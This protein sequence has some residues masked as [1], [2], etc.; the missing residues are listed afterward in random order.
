[1]KGDYS[2][3]DCWLQI[4]EITK[5]VDTFYIYSTVY[6]DSSFEDG[7]SD[8]ASLDTPEMIAGALGEYEI[9][10]IGADAQIVLDRGVVVTNT[11]YDQY[12][13]AEF[14]GPQSFHEDYYTI[15]YNNIKDNV[16]KRIASYK[17]GHQ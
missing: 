2:Q 9:T 4:P 12:A 13:A 17:A 10:D 1:M 15:Y 7:A 11:R 6:V 16:A 14:F 3:E 5:Y 8:Y